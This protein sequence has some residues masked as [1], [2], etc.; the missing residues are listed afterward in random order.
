MGTEFVSVVYIQYID[1]I[2]ARAGRPAKALLCSV[3]LLFLFFIPKI[4]RPFEGLNVLKK[5]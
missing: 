3:G 5:L 2:R 4:K 1:F